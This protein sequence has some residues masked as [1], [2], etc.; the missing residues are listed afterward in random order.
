M[1]AKGDA[2]PPRPLGSLGIGGWGGEESLTRAPPR[3]TR[4]LRDVPVPADTSDH[5][6][7]G[8]RGMVYYLLQMAG[9]VSR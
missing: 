9:R 8:T 3:A 7:R 6:T 1:I 2:V 4:D 5:A